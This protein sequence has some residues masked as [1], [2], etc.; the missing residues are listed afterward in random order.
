MAPA[1]VSSQ[2]SESSLATGGRTKDELRDAEPN[3]PEPDARFAGAPRMRGDTLARSDSDPIDV[4]FRKLPPYDP[5]ND[6]AT[7][8]LPCRCGTG[9]GTAR[10][11]AEGIARGDTDG[12]A[13]GDVPGSWIEGRR[14]SG[15]EWGSGTG[16]VAM[17]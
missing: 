11:E 12:I 15:D 3:E 8:M 7:E 14:R 5:A 6:P 17:I 1:R 13:R 4:L 2:V 10:G 16:G 9:R